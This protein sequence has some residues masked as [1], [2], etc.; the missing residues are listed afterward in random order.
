MKVYNAAYAA[1]M[2]VY[3]ETGNFAALR[4]EIEEKR[5]DLIVVLIEIEEPAATAA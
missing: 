4:A 3:T 1:A 2:K 5:R